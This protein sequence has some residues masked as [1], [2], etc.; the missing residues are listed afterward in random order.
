MHYFFWL[1]VGHI[2]G[3]FFLQIYKLWRLKRQSGY[4]LLLHVWL[5]TVSLTVTL[6]FIDLFAW[7]KPVVLF[8]SHFIADY[9]KCYVFSFRT[10]R[11]KLLGYALDQIVHVA[12]LVMLLPW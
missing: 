3:D 2:T 10:S 8:I 5:Y 4:Y 1:L 12:V 11:D 6:Y 7:W 9:L